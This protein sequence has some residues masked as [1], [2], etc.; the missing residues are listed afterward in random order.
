MVR[1]ECRDH[2]TRAAELE[3]LA[4]SDAEP[5]LGELATVLTPARVR[6]VIPT[7]RA[8]EELAKL[9]AEIGA[10]LVAVLAIRS[11]R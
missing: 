11:A 6:T 7:G 5:R 4:R 10:D 3:A 9:A 2:H 1:A 8:H